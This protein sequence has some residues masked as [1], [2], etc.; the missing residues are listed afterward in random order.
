LRELPHQICFDLLP[1]ICAT[2]PCSDGDGIFNDLVLATLAMLFS[3]FRSL[4]VIS[5]SV[6]HVSAATNYASNAEA[7]L[8]ALMKWYNNSTGIWD[9]TGW[10]NS[11]NALT[12]LGDF[13]AVDR[14]RKSEA[15]YVFSNSI[16]QAQ[17]YNLGISKIITADYNIQ[18]IANDSA[19]V[20]P[21]GFLNG[22]Y[23]DEGWW[24]LAWIQAYDVTGD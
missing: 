21:K 20:N 23:D 11:A 9:T 17:N 15:Q 13:A 2:L 10:W 8:T 6:R 22:Y 16:V 24:A 19:A 18:T 12:M 7:A 3:A 5:A 4:F 1:Y 14:N